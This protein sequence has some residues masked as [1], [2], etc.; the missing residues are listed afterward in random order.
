MA[1]SLHSETILELGKKIVNELGLDESV[2][3][4]GRWMSHYVAELIHAAET[5]Q[6]EERQAKLAQCTTAILQLWKHRNDLPPGSRPFEGFEPA[7]RALESLDPSNKI[8]RYFEQLC[9]EANENEKN[10]ES[11]KWLSIADALDASAKI[12]IRHCI[13]RAAELAS[14]KS[15]HWL[16]LAESAGVANS[17]DLH[18]IR[19]IL[20]ESDKV[21]P[22]DLRRKEIEDRIKRLEEFTELAAAVAADLRSQLRRTDIPTADS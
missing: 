14:D 8:P 15:K 22:D 16:S 13:A 18:V 9:N 7:L 1:V 3:T 20:D 2:D 5:A 19:I 10:P 11:R 17:V 12:L 4:L 21:K 6:P